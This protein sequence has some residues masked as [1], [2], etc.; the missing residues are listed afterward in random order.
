LSRLDAPIIDANFFGNMVLGTSETHVWQFF[1]RQSPGCIAVLQRVLSTDELARSRRFL[2]R[3]HQS[4]FVVARGVLRSILS[5]Y[6]DCPAEALQIRYGETGKPAL[7]SKYRSDI[8]FN[9]S[10][11]HGLGV[12]AVTERRPI[13][14]DIEYIDRNVDWATIANR[15]FSQDERLQLWRLEPRYQRFAFYRIWTR[16]EAYLKATGIGLAAALP[17]FQSVPSALIL[18]DPVLVATET[19]LHRWTIE[20]LALPPQY[21]GSLAT[22]DSSNRLIYFKWPDDLAAD[23]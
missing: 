1:L 11:S 7:D 21:T 4:R 12:V 23:L 14:I 16:K 15:F 20:Q 6:L 18:T 2:R 17:S 19:S 22:T 8:H 3:D 9:L 10:H 13:G 5:C